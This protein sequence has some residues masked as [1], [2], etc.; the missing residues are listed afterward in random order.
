M[1]VFMATNIGG[2]IVGWLVRLDYRAAQG[3]PTRAA[4]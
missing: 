3:V 4:A 2:L 1:L